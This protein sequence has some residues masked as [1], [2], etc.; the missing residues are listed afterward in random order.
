MAG[1]GAGGRTRRFLR[2]KP[3][4]RECTSVLGAAGAGVVVTDDWVTD[5]AL[6]ARV[7]T[8]LREWEPPGAPPEGPRFGAACRRAEPGDP[9]AD[10]AL[11][12]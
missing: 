4:Q 3:A 6:L 2:P 5:P 10:I 8:L 11:P 12:R 7:H 9:P 1:T